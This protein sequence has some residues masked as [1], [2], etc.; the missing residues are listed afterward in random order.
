MNKIEELKIPT[1]ALINGACL[2]GGLEL[3]LACTYRLAV[4]SNKNTAWTS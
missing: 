2:G 1:I 3:A 4:V